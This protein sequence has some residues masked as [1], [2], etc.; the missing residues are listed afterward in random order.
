MKSSRWNLYFNLVGL[1]VFLLDRP[2][3]II[4]FLSYDKCNERF[5]GRKKEV[6]N[7]NFISEV[8][9]PDPLTV[10]PTKLPY[11]NYQSRMSH[12]YRNPSVN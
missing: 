2:F 11:Q 7:A 4:T 3:P 8:Y 1:H 10:S 9:R 12:L 5:K 6:R